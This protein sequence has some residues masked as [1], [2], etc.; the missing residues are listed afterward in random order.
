MRTGDPVRE[1]LFSWCDV[2]RILEEICKGLSEF[3][4][5]AL[6][7]L[8]GRS[9]WRGAAAPAASADG[10]DGGRYQQE[11]EQNPLNQTA[12]ELKDKRQKGEGD[13]I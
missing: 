8:Q 11:L 12:E 1:E 7:I 9:C 13:R 2:E 6:I 4:V 3:C 5:S 10:R